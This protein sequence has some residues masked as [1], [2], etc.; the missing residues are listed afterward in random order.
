MTPQDLIAWR[1]ANGL[2]QG[3]AAQRMDVIVRTWQRYEYGQLPIPP[4][5]VAYCTANPLLDDTS[6]PPPA[7]RMEEEGA[8][9]ARKKTPST[10]AEM[11]AA[12]LK[13][14]DDYIKG[15]VAIPEKYGASCPYSFAVSYW[16]DGAMVF[17]LVYYGER[18]VTPCPAAYRAGINMLNQAYNTGAL[19]TMLA[20]LDDCPA[21]IKLRAVPGNGV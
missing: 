21:H 16:F 17:P 5:V 8:K 2:T 6:P 13:M 9:P 20:K 4:A 3:G 18:G 1:K 10:E 19:W 11:V 14:A 15:M 12:A 7:I